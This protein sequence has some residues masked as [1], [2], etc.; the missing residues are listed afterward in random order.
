M[1]F[2]GLLDFMRKISLFGTIPLMVLLMLVTV[3]LMS[4][5]I[6]RTKFGR[7]IVA[8]GGNETNAYLSGIKVVTYK[9]ITYMISGLLVALASFVFAARMNSIA[10]AAGSG[11][12]LDA[13]VA[14]VIGG[15]TF[16]GGRGTVSGA[17][18]GCLLTGVISSALDILGVDAYLKI[19]ITGV[20]IVI[21]VVLSNID[22]IRRKV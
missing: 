19:A 9:I 4:L 22:N 21:A 17:M 10:P 11:Y 16:E 8:M 14:C 3:V 12:E 13:L 18:L 7:R 1:S 6:N 15:I 20:I 2:N 5:L